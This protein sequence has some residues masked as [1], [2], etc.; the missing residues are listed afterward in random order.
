MIGGGAT[1]L[2]LV[3]HGETVWTREHRYQGVT[4]TALTTKGRRQARALAAFLRRQHVDVLIT[5]SLRRAKE[6]GKII[7]QAIHRRPR[8][9]VQL[10][11]ISFG[12]W[13]GKTAKELIRKK[14]RIFFKWCEWKFVT[15][16]GG[17]SPRAAQQRTALALRAIL[18]RHKGKTVAVVSHGGPI[19]MM[20]SDAL[21]WRF[22][23]FASI[24][25][26]PASLSILDFYPHFIQCHS[27][28]NTSHLLER[29]TTQ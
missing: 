16:P 29:N 1:R 24:R 9:I 18:R 15:P 11:E 2:I 3:R 22:R 8:S 10:N 23:S 4:D 17:E 21:N 25:I 7:A 13:E 12:H 19:K 14:D 5:S 20:I 27:I 28:N 6:T 26:D